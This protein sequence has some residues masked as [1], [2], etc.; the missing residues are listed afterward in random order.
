MLRPAAQGFSFGSLPSSTLAPLRAR[1]CLPADSGARASW[2]LGPS[3][4]APHLTHNL[5]LRP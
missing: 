1:L 3:E 2:G 4:W 5:G